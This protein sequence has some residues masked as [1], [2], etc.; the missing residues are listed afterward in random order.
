MPEDIKTK[1]LEAVDGS[2]MSGNTLKTSM[3]LTQMP[4]THDYIHNYLTQK[5]WEALENNGLWPGLRTLVARLKQIGVNSCKEGIKRQVLAILVLVECHQ[6]QMPRYEDIYDLGEHFCQ[7]FK[8]SA[9]RCAP[10][11]P[12]L[13]EYP[14]HPSDISSDFISLAYPADDPPVAKHLEDLNYIAWNHIPLRETSKLLKKNQKKKSQGNKR[15]GKAGSD[16]EEDWERAQA[17][18]QRAKRL[19]QENES[20]DLTL[21]FKAEKFKPKKL[22]ALS[23]KPSFASTSSHERIPEAPAGSGQDKVP[24]KQLEASPPLPLALPAPAP[25]ESVPQDTIASPKN[26][27]KSAQQLEDE[28]FAKLQKK[29]QEKEVKKAVAK[30]KAAAKGKS[31]PKAAPNTKVLKRPAAKQPSAGSSSGLFG[32]MRCRGNVNG[33]SECKKDGCKGEICHGRE[34][35]K[36]ALAKKGKSWK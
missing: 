17:M 22:Q 5:D 34:A 31:T 27:Q 4:Q 18:L 25:Q 33:C 21:D 26:D 7:K 13:A 29:E 35:W 15:K 36:A 20:N 28:A 14:E 9:V 3:K 6:R 32:C 8:S 19:L 30:G 24:K 23:S 10:G 12:S 11:V 2:V 1:I 16:S